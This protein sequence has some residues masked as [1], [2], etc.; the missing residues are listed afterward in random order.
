MTN[1]QDSIAKETREIR[2]DREEVLKALNML[3]K[4]TNEYSSNSE[5]NRL[6]L[7]MLKNKK[8]AG[9]S[10]GLENE[11]KCLKS[12]LDI[13][14]YFL[15]KLCD[16]LESEGYSNLGFHN[17]F[18]IIEN[19]FRNKETL[20]GEVLEIAD[21][22]LPDCFS[23][24][25]RYPDGREPFTWIEHYSAEDMLNKHDYSDDTEYQE[26]IE[27]EAERC[28]FVANYGIDSFTKL[29]MAYRAIMQ[30]LKSTN[31]ELIQV[32]KAIH[33]RERQIVILTNI[34]KRKWGNRFAKTLK[35]HGMQ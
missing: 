28:R 15:K 25:W 32:E 8:N 22:E 31:E 5:I 12:D 20:N 4:L 9:Y 21:R 19:T 27:I 16:D 13:F 33:R 14:K 26:A 3:E 24:Y 18:K 29:T 7:R 2:K 17:F 1:T 34:I 35:E 10:S 23:F 11:I 30:D 6:S